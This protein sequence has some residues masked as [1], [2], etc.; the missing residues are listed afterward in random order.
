MPCSRDHVRRAGGAHS[1]GVSHRDLKL[2]NLMLRNDEEGADVKL[3]DFGFSKIFKVCLAL[4]AGRCDRGDGTV[5]QGRCNSSARTGARACFAACPPAG[6]P[7][8][9]AACCHT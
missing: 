1:R 6:T 5:A 7:A 9:V 4:R 8:H 2:E 3:I